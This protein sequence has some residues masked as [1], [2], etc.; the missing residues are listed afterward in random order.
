MVV[1][2]MC[3]VF[4]RIPKK[5]LNAI[6]IYSE[7]APRRP[8]GRTLNMKLSK[9]DVVLAGLGPITYLSSQ[10]GEAATTPAHPP[11]HHHPPVLPR[12]ACCPPPPSRPPTPPPL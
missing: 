2:C 4:F 9:R 3:S 7:A 10:S 1:Q 5:Q 12:P 11:P 6:P 8:P